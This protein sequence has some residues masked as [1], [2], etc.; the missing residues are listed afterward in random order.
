M[1]SNEFLFIL[2]RNP[3]HKPT[4]RATPIS[5]RSEAMALAVAVL[6]LLTLLSRKETQDNV[7][8]K[9][10][11]TFFLLCA[12]GW[13]PIGLAP[14]LFPFLCPFVLRGLTVLDDFNFHSIFFLFIPKK[15]QVKL[16][17]VLGLTVT[18]NAALACDPNTGTIAYPAGY[19]AT[20]HP[21]HSIII[22]F[23]IFFVIFFSGKK[24]CQVGRWSI[25]SP[26]RWPFRCF[27]CIRCAFLIGALY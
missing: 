20:V 19:V 2:Y 8:A 18:S 12:V 16:E 27:D 9:G 15:T 21:R 4:H 13:P 14:P 6:V 23:F 17:R 26:S 22:S 7:R 1:Q 25:I 5:L 3:L 24:C 10:G 11:R